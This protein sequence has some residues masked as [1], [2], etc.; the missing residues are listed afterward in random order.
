[1]GSI[2]FFSKIQFLFEYKIFENNLLEMLNGQQIIICIPIFFF[3]R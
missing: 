2:D 1:M 3:L